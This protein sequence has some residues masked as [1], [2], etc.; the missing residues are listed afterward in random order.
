MSPPM[1]AA[2]AIQSARMSAKPA[3]R[4]H[5]GKPLRHGRRQ[6]LRTMSRPQPR[7]PRLSGRSPD[8]AFAKGGCS[9]LT[10][11][12]MAT[13]SASAARSPSMRMPA[14]LAPRAEKIVRP[15]QRQSLPQRRRAGSDRVMQRQHGDEREL[16]RAVRRRRIGQQQRGVEVAGRRDPGIAAAAAAGGLLPRRDPERTALARARKR[17]RLGIG[18]GQR[19][20]KPTD[21]SPPPPP[22]RISRIRTATGRRRS[23]RRP[24]VPDR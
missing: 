18:R 20:M 24:A 22:P 19:V 1:P 12:P 5:C 15:F 3:P 17:Q 4:R 13:A 9:Q 21:D 11:M 10:P 7:R 16:R 8:R 23:R 2:R 14:S 6:T